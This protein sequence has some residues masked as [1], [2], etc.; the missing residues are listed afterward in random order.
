M[1]ANTTVCLR[2][3]VLTAAGCAFITAAMLVTALVVLDKPHFGWLVGTFFLEIITSGVMVGSVM[4]LAGAWNLPQRTQWR[5]I[6]LLA[7]G[8]VAL[9]SPAFGM[10]FLLP[11]GLLALTLPVVVAI[12]IAFSRGIEPARETAA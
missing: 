12:L 6:V 9:T 5:G 8:L 2:W 1:S 11:W 3:L 4:L 10:L 7:W